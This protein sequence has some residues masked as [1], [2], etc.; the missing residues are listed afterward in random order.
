[1]IAGNAND[2]EKRR[3]EIFQNFLIKNCFKNFPN[4]S[5]E[6]PTFISYNGRDKS[7]IVHI[8]IPKDLFPNI[9]C[10]T[11][12]FLQINSSDHN[13]VQVKFPISIETLKLPSKVTIN[14]KPPWKKADIDAYQNVLE[15]TLANLEVVYD[16]E[17][18]ASLYI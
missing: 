10:D 16:F 7:N 6:T 17:F 9:E 15:K 5:P 12:I 2:S 18:E 4:A 8:I 1:M 14:N 13:P 11:L 3:Y